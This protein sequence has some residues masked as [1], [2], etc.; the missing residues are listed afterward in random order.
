MKFN[1]GLNVVPYYPFLSSKRAIY[2]AEYTEIFGET[3]RRRREGGYKWR[4]RRRIKGLSSSAIC[5]K[6]HVHLFFI[7]QNIYY[8]GG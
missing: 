5:E 4:G 2:T 6:M 7:R 1:N 8:S 3:Q